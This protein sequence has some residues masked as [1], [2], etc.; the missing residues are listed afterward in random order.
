MTTKLD[1][2]QFTGHTPGPWQAKADY[3]SV[4]VMAH[5]GEQVCGTVP[6]S[7]VNARLIAAAPALLAECRRLRAENERLYVS[8]KR[9]HA[10]GQSGMMINHPQ[11]SS[12]RRDDHA[13]IFEQAR[14]ALEAVSNG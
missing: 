14:L 10:L 1:L 7:E 2:T 8:L 3:I 6:V 5:C 12:E 9:L 11:C 4:R 13:A